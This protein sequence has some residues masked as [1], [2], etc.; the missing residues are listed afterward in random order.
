MFLES[1]AF[2][3]VVDEQR[4]RG[5]NLEGEEITADARSEHPRLPL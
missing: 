5:L 3:R 4:F 2:A 1:N